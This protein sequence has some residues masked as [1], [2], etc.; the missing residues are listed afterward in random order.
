MYFEEDGLTYVQCVIPSFD[1]LK[2]QKTSPIDPDDSFIIEVSNNG[3][4]FSDSKKRFKFI[5]VDQL[6]RVYPT[7]GPEGGGTVLDITI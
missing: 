1:Y 5:T 7:T 2:L 3:K 4:D 6:L